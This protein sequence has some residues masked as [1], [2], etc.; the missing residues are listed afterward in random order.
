MTATTQALMGHTHLSFEVLLLSIYM[1]EGAERASRTI[2]SPSTRLQENFSLRYQ[3][4]KTLVS[5]DLDRKKPIIQTSLV[6]D[7]KVC[8]VMEDEREIQ[9]RC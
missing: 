2:G 3:G 1:P 5:D 9:N 7:T 4:G 8:K 6:K